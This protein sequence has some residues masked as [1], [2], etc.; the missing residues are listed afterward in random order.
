MRRELGR[1]LG[2]AAL[3]KLDSL[4]QAGFSAIEADKAIMRGIERRILET[5]TP[6]LTQAIKATVNR[7]IKTGVR[8]AIKSSLPGYQN[9][10]LDSA[11]FQTAL[12]HRPPSGPNGGR[13]VSLHQPHRRRRGPSIPKTKHSLKGNSAAPQNSV[14]VDGILREGPPICY[15]R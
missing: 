11:V 1:E 10:E 15:L 8:K 14:L 7:S 6:S 2:D 12:N 4:A 5:V 13:V 9:A 3:T